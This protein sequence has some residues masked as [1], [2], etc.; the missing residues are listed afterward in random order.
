[1]PK[2]LFLCLPSMGDA[3]GNS[4]GMRARV[5]VVLSHRLHGQLTPPL[6]GALKLP[7]FTGTG[8]NVIPSETVFPML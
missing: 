1:M 5:I 6:P 2:S 7:R 8:G 3:H 4:A